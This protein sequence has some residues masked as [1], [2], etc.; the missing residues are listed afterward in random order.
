MPCPKTCRYG[1]FRISRVIQD[2]DGFE[3]QDSHSQVSE[4]ECS[5]K[6]TEICGH[7]LSRVPIVCA[8]F[9]VDVQSAAMMAVHLS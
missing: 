5:L 6:L 1:F 4:N 9:C 8:G 2:D 3:L 7:I